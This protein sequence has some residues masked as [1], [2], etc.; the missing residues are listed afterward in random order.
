M[1]HIDLRFS[2]I[3]ACIVLPYVS[4]CIP[5][6][7]LLLKGRDNIVHGPFWLG[8]VGKVANVVLLCF[9]LFAI[10]MYSLP[11]VMPVTPESTNHTSPRD[12]RIALTCS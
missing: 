1:S 9:T 8:W 7:L 6:A 4:Y 5:T 11:T 10:I 2:I 12:P 3:S